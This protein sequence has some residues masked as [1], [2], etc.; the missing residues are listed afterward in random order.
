MIT[1]S[2]AKKIG[3]VGTPVS[4]YLQTVGAEGWN[5]KHGYLYNIKIPDRDGEEHAFLAYGME[6]IGDCKY[7]ISVSG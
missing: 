5:L 2:L 7:N 1:Y 3:L 6:S 4:Y